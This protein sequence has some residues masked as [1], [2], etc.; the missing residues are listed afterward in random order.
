[1]KSK[2]TRPAMDASKTVKNVTRHAAMS[3]ASGGSGGGKKK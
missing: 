1:M 2:S 3:K